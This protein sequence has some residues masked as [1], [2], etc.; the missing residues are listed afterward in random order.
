MSKSHHTNKSSFGPVVLITGASSG[1]GLAAAHKFSAEGWRVV[2][3]CRNPGSCPELAELPGVLALPLDVT[4]P[5]S[6]ET[7]VTRIVSE[8][9]QI[10]VLVNNAGYGVDGIFEAMTDSAIARQFETNVF[11][12]MRVTRAVLPQMRSQRRGTIIQISSMGG[13]TTFPLY[14]IY[15]GSKWAVEGFS[16]SLAFELRPSGIR[17]KLI[18]PGAVQTDFYHRN[19][20]TVP[21]EQLHEYETNFQRCEQI[22]MKEAQRGC[23]AEVVAKVIYRAAVDRSGRLRYPAGRQASF[24]L[25]LRRL[26]PESVFMRLIRHVYGIH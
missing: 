10:D 22:S 2:A 8:F 24:L 21:P 14:S 16:E 19:R 26:L 18:E 3:T 5:E 6:I 7:A 9:G 12:L 11:G 23:S 17:V 13:R 1:I 15:H 4:L 25:R 20:E